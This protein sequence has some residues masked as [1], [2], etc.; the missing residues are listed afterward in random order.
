MEGRGGGGAGGGVCSTLWGGRKR[1]ISFGESQAS[2]IRSNAGG[3]VEGGVEKPCNL[4]SGFGTWSVDS[5]FA[6]VLL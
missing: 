1:V 6:M 2:T 4:I 3:W 5:G